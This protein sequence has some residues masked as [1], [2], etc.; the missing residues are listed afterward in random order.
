MRVFTEM[1]RPRPIGS[2]PVVRVVHPSGTLKNHEAAL[3]RGLCKLERSGCEVRWESEKLSS[4]W[5]DYLA[6]RDAERFHELEAALT[7]PEVDIIWCARGGSGLNRILHPIIQSA[8]NI[9]P[10]IIIGFSDCTSLLNGLAIHA[11]WV[12]FHGPVVTMLDSDGT[13][14][15]LD[16]AFAKLDGAHL[17]PKDNSDISVQGHLLGGN[18]TVLASMCGDSLKR[19]WQSP[20]VLLL[21]DVNE[22]PYRLD[23]SF[24]QLLNSGTFPDLRALWWGD[25]DLPESS[26]HSVIETLSTDAGVPHQEGAPAGHKGYV[27]LLPIGSVGRLNLRDGTFW[28]DRPWVRRLDD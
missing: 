24:W 15:D 25:L 9:S 18:L 26:A 28:T 16:A 4:S 10:K 8:Q 1:K 2:R 12:T 22:S 3:E 13:A 27:E 7:E 17:V 5:R 6:G 19:P 20:T 11:Q 23:R 14:F 21:E